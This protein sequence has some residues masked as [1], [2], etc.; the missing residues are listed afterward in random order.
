MNILKSSLVF[1]TISTSSVQ[2]D[3][4]REED[5][6]QINKAIKKQI[7]KSEAP[8]KT[9]YVIVFYFYQ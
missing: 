3:L 1:I 6:R 8:P 4:S 9:V 7:K 5:M 2:A